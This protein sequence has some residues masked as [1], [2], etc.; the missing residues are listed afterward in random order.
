MTI[1][2]HEGIVFLYKTD[3]THYIFSRTYLCMESFSWQ[4]TNTNELY[5]CIKQILPIIFFKN[6]FVYG[7]LFMTIQEYERIIFLYKTDITNYKFFQN[8]IVCG[9]LFMTIYEQEGIIFLYKSDITNYIFSRIY[10]CMEAFS[11]QYTNKKELYVCIKQILPVIF[12]PRIYLC[13]ENL[14]WQYRYYQ[15]YI[16]SQL[17]C[18][19]EPFYEN[20]DISVIYF[21]QN[22]FVYG[23]LFMTIQILLLYFI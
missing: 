6:L 15:L 16:F 17:I 1:H 8:L 22:L 5:F 12:F 19:W 10:L 18:V 9:S 7:S 11:W 23:N 13:M 20:T 2:E 14:S 21:F 3:I 4:Y